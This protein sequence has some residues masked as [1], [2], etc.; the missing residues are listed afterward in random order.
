MSGNVYYAQK[1]PKTCDD[2]V[3]WLPKTK[4]WKSACF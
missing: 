4:I 3:P 1:I 2:L